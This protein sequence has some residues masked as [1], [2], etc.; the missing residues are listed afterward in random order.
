MRIILS[1]ILWLAVAPILCSA[2]STQTP[3]KQLRYNQA[4]LTFEEN[5]GQT[6]PQVGFISRSQGYTA[7]LKSDGMVLALRSKDVIKS[8]VRESILQSPRKHIPTKTFEFRLV[9]AAANATASGEDPQPGRVNYFIG[10]DPNKW[11]TNLRTYRRIRY[12][13]VYPGI[14]LVY[15]GNPRQ[16]EYDFAVAPKADPGAIQFEIRGAQRVELSADG[17]LIVKMGDGELHF[18]SPTVYQTSNGARVPLRGKYVMM[19][20]TRVGFRVHGVDASKPLVIDP[21]LIYSTYLGGSG[22]DLPTGIAVDGT[23]A[24]YISGYT[25]SLD[26]PQATIGSLPPGTDHVF[27]TKFDATGT[28]LVYSDYI[29][30]NSQDYGYALALNSANEVYVTGSTASSDFPTVNAYQGT[31]PGSFNAFL[32]RISSDGSSLLY[33]TYLGGNGSDIPSKLAVDSLSQATIIGSTSSTNFPVANAYQSTASPNQGGLYG[34]Y[35]FITKFGTDGSSLAYSTY[36]AGSANVPLQCGTSTCWTSP[37]TSLTGLALGSD[38]HAYVVGTTNTYD[39]PVTQGAYST[40]NTTQNNSSVGFVSNLDPTGALQ[41]STYFYESFGFT[42]L[43]GI[44]ADSTGSAYVTGLAFSDGTFPITSTS[45]CDPEVSQTACSYAFVA[46]FDPTVSTL[47]YSTF[48][49]VNNYAAPVG[50]VLDQSNDAYVLATTSSDSFATVN[51][52]QSY[53]GGNDVLLVEIDPEAGSQLFATYLGGSSDEIAAGMALD[54]NGN[55]YITGTTDS[56]DFPTKQAFQNA[57]GGNTDGFVMK[58]GGS[59][60]PVVSLAP[61]SLSFAAQTVGS[62][63]APQQVSLQNLGNTTLSV[64]SIFAAG[65]FSQNNTCGTSV[66]ASGTCTLSVTFT[67][68]TAS[69]RTGSITIN[70]DA[71]GAPHVISLSGTGV[72]ASV[73]LSPTSLVFAATN[74]GSSSAAQSV[75]LSNPGSSSVRISGAQI[76]G[77]FTQTNNCASSLAAGSSCTL[78]VTFTPTATGNRTGSLTITDSA[79]GSPQTVSLSGSGSDFSLAG[80]PSS[81]TIKAGSTAT[82]TVTVAPVGGSFPNQVQMGCTGAPST[83]TCTMTP[84]SVTP[85]SNPASV[86]ITVATA[87]ASSKSATPSLPS[88]KPQAYAFWMQLQGLGLSAMVLIGSIRRRKRLV[89]LVLLALLASGLLFMTACAGG[90]GIVS[91]GKGTASGTYTV[92]IK[93]TSGSLQHSV[94]LTLT[95]Q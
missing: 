36:F 28:N 14:D 40:S 9:G 44:A 13:N 72:A 38:G 6:A 71:S 3:I 46:K 94:P 68:T 52:L 22:D 32:T 23:G 26:F 48:L 29:G 15:Y 91:G 90:T 7:F 47:T 87:A 25:D 66:P 95:V 60:G 79:A 88:Q 1:A 59:S 86:T 45:I 31:Y 93:G 55:L 65:D 20:A 80:S 89:A 42:D 27:V 49:G 82:F 33:S 43:T 70:D 11:R 57:P 69:L 61:T 78:R 83:T 17:N 85:G 64:S 5:R 50:I 75:T 4:P 58:I 67:P 51:G 84:S 18:Q 76:S 92:T 2:Q 62:T 21:V 12:K 24:V 39:F 30:G 53:A 35:G 8:T 19:G 10:S 81:S 77:D 74:V 34:T 73:A 63:S 37:S 54:G 56:N 16:L 41:Y